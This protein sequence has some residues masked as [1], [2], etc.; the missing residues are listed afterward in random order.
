[1][2]AGAAATGTDTSSAW[3]GKPA[4]SHDGPPRGHGV[5]TTRLRMP[6]RFGLHQCLPARSTDA[7]QSKVTGLEIKRNQTSRGCSRNAAANPAP[8]SRSGRRLPRASDR[9][10]TEG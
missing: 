9:W 1:M 5:P 6:V 3:V 2:A 8:S 7:T 10:N 4:G